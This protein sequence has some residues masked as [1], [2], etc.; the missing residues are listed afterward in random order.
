MNELTNRGVKL[1]ERIRDTCA[2]FDPV[3]EDVLAAARG[4]L[5]WGLAQAAPS[6]GAA[7][8]RTGAENLPPLRVHTSAAATGGILPYGVLPGWQRSDPGFAAPR[9]VAVD[10]TRSTADFTNPTGN[11]Q[12]AAG[13]F[14]WIGARVVVRTRPASRLRWSCFPNRQHAR[15]GVV[16]RL[17]QHRGH[18][19]HAL[20][21]LR[22]S[23]CASPK[24][25]LKPVHLTCRARHARSHLG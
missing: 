9:V 1:M 7:R 16:V 13:S 8:V 12:L 21:D 2:E 20:S 5:G 10:S 6:A 4:A 15:A 19:V 11:V 17:L 25:A 3:P 23:R 24:S 18:N 22:S 14:A